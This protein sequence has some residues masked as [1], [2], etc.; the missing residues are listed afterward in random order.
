[1]NTPEEVA[2]AIARNVRVYRQRRGWTLDALAER[3]GVSKGMV[4][5]IEQGKTNPSIATLTRVANALGVAVPR[6]VEV[7]DAPPVRLVRADEMPELW[8]GA[9]GG[10]ALLAA[11]TDAPSPAE[12]W[13][14]RM[15]PGDA[16]DGEAHEPDTRELLYVLE[17]VL[18]LRVGHARQE[19]AAGEAV[20]F[21]ADRPH[22]YANESA[23][24][25]RFVMTVVEPSPEGASGA[26][27][28]PAEG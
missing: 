22:R 12:L 3:S 19:V 16:Y 20:L 25:L 6:L 11:G 14:W 8:T 5:Q 7:A 17:G 27:P 9:G 13:D 10:A 28:G 18:S 4:V 1:M 23:A 21:R 2:A 24:P 26:G 15:A